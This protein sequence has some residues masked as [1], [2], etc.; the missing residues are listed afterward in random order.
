MHV[1]IFVIQKKKII[2]KYFFS[3]ES[4]ENFNEKFLDKKFPD[5]IRLSNLASI[6]QIHS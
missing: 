3:L 5:S 6:I 1:Y 4:N 2:I